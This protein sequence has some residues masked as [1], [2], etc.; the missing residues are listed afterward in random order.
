MVIYIK[1]NTISE[2]E[3]FVAVTSSKDYDI[4]L[5]AKD[6]IVDAKSVMCILGLDLTKPVKLKADCKAAGELLHQL[7]PFLYEKEL[8]A[9]GE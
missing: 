1:F 9:R 4:V 8:L 3:R 5:E 2:V 6:T 7:K